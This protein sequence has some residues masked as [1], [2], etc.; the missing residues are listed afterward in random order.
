M[1]LITINDA[2]KSIRISD[3]LVKNMVIYDNKWDMEPCNTAYSFTSWNKSP[4]N[5]DEWIYMLNRL[6]YANHLII[7]YKHTEKSEYLDKWYDIVDSWNKNNMHFITKKNIYQNNLNIPLKLLKK[8]SKI[9]NPSFTNSVRTLD[10]AIRCFCIMNDM[11]VLKKMKVLDH[12]KE[13]EYNNNIYKQ[14]EYLKDNYYIGFTHNNWGMIQSSCSLYCLILL[15]L[16][17]SELFKWNYDMLNKC[18]KNQILKDGS[19]IEN[20]PMYHVEILMY[21][22]HMIYAM[23][24]KNIQISDY[25]LDN[26]KR[27]SSYLYYNSN[28]TIYNIGDSDLTNIS[29][30]M[31]MLFIIL[32]DDKYLNKINHKIDESFQIRFFEEKDSVYYKKQKE[33]P[34]KSIT[35]N[36]NSVNVITKKINLFIINDGKITDHRHS[37]MGHF[38]LYYNNHPIMIDSGRYT[39]INNKTRLFLKSQFAHNTLFMDNDELIKPINSWKFLNQVKE[40]KIKLLN[41]SVIEITYASENVRFKR[42]F[43]MLEEGLLIIN[44]V[45]NNT[46][47]YVHTANRLYHINND[48]KVNQH[49]NN[50]ELTINKQKLYF[51]TNAES[52]SI[53]NSIV[54]YKYNELTS[55]QKIHCSNNFNKK[56]LSYDFISDRIID[57]TF[58]DES[59]IINGKIIKIIIDKNNEKGGVI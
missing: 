48:I 33:N 30:I 10:T 4:N 45:I 47:E 25:L 37:D 51:Y 58:N 56:S 13:T 5:D 50:I 29:E 12:D 7:A 18:I 2:E 1:E 39:Y 36:N 46:D 28:T 23:R 41:D 52:V 59:V 34:K 57:F 15:G 14:L 22:S 26:Y 32:K 53:N 42:Q 17:N 11:C 43:F 38:I 35:K 55:N 54:S 6:E 31:Y 24:N 40:S 3:L 21:L 16:Y 20:T 27:M 19:Q 44:E 49:K 8:I 9:V